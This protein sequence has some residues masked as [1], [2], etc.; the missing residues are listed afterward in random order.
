M[1]Y[2]ELVKVFG[3]FFAIMN[4][5]VNLPIFLVMTED[6]EQSEQ[7]RL[8]LK[9]ACYSVF[10]CVVILVAG[11]AILNFFG[12]SID[13]FRVA[14]GIVLASIAWSMLHGGQSASHHGSASE[15]EE[16]SSLSVMAFYPMTFPM[17]VGPGTIAT[18]IIYAAHAT[19]YIQ[20]LEI[21]AVLLVILS[22]L[23]IVFY[24]ASSIGKVL[25]QSVR[26]IMNRLMG[27]I[28]L[29]ISVEMVF[30]GAKALL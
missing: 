1:D 17:I 16:L 21:A 12:V 6:V 22:L 23:F 25:S 20:S 19:N 28:L 14:G 2:T 10:M 3:A 11:Q 4:P 26:L 5:F 30:S 18:I 27:M 15:K 13:D 29:A 24:N 8:A 7:R 9:I